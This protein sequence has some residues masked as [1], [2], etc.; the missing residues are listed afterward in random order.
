MPAA[1]QV[2]IRSVSLPLHLPPL[3]RDALLDVRSAVN[4][5]V[6][7]W[8]AHPWESRF[9]ATKRTY[10]WTRAHYPHLAS[11]WAVCIANETSATLN[12]WDRQLRRAKRLDVRKWQRLRHQLPRRIRLKVSLHAELYRLRGRR[13]DI[14]LH[15][16]RH[17]LIDLS[18]IPHPLFERYGAASNW[19]FGLTVTDRYLVFHF[20]VPQTGTLAPNSVGVDV[21]MPSADFVTSDAQVGSVDLRPITAIQGSMARK[22]HSVQRRIPKDLRLQRRVLRRY[23]G[24]ERRRVEPLLHRAANEFLAKAGGRNIVL[25][26]LSKTQEELMRT[27][28]G[29]DARRRLSAWT[30]GRFQRFVEYKARTQVV[31]V[32]PRGTSS[33]CPRC[34]GR[35]DHPEWRRSVCVNCQ[36]DWQRDRAAA[37]SILSRGLVTLWGAAPPPKA[38]DALL[39]LSRWGSG[40]DFTDRRGRETKRS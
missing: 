36:G 17:L 28:R 30:Q 37:T 3:L 10:A 7:D 23:R 25:E 29:R 14:T 22:R 4:S 18:R 40:T 21:N 39:E 11:G 34:G 6:P 27:T 12:S 9:D 2:S 33:E 1:R 26:D 5:L 24:R 35:L 32:D 31:H 19:K 20:R 16:D 8:R 13:L 15:R 38:L